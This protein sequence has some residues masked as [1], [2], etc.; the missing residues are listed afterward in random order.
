MPVDDNE[1]TE[2]LDYISNKLASDNDVNKYEVL[3][4]Q[5]RKA[6]VGTNECS[7]NDIYFT[8]GKYGMPNINKKGI[9]LCDFCTQT[10]M[11]IV[12]TFFEKPSYSTWKSFTNNTHFDL[13]RGTLT[14]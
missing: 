10:D 11:F 5:D 7:N 9:E 14:L 8:V 2:M 6:Q 1:H 12:N 4:G 3:I 13:S